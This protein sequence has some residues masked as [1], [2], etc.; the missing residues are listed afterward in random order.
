MHFKKTMAAGAA[1]ALPA[2]QATYQCP[3][4]APKEVTALKY[5]YAVQDFLYKYYDANGPY[6]ASGFANFPNATMMTVGGVTIAEAVA[7]NMNGL[8]QQAMLGVEAIKELASNV[9][10]DAM[11]D[12]CDYSYPPLLMDAQSMDFVQAIYYIEATLCG[13]FIGMSKLYTGLTQLLIFN[14][15]RGLRP[16][17]PGCLLDGP[18]LRRTRHPRV[19]LGTLLQL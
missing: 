2:V 11:W 10:P 8:T 13:T 18:P 9:N 4:S 15:S 1:L 16:D 3:I 17:T 12:E 7:S 14:R 6:D 5:A 19:V